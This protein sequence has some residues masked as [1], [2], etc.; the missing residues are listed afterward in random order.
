MWFI[1][2]LVTKL[3][4]KVEELHK[5]KHSPYAFILLSGLAYV[6]STAVLLCLHNSIQ[7]N[8]EILCVMLLRL[9]MFNLLYMLHVGVFQVVFTIKVNCGKRYARVFFHNTFEM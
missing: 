5:Q 6:Y 9:K 4:R 8:D 3:E 7:S 2:F 1:L